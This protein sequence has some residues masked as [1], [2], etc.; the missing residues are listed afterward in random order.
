MS[1]HSRKRRGVRE[2]TELSDATPLLLCM[3]LSVSRRVR[4]QT[5]IPK[6][7][8]VCRMLTSSSRPDVAER[9]SGLVAPK[10]DVENGLP[11]RASVAGSRGTLENSVFSRCPNG[12]PVRSMAIGGGLRPP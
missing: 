2:D 10:Q 3:T 7:P 9:A 5:Y 4:W 11:G 8:M 6:S 1:K 12:P